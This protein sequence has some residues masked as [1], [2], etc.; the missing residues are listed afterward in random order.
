MHYDP[1]P[2]DDVFFGE[3]GM[4]VL[5][6]QSKPQRIIKHKQTNKQRSSIMYEWEITSNEVTDTRSTIELSILND[7]ITNC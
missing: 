1:K 3:C 7:H 4:K 6:F 2:K 5:K